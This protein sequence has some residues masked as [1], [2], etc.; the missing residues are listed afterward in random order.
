MGVRRI[1]QQPT[2]AGLLAAFIQQ[3]EEQPVTRRF[4]VTTRNDK[5]IQIDVTPNTWTCEVGIDHTR[6]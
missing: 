2:Y 5:T 4:V 1:T 3:A 6:T